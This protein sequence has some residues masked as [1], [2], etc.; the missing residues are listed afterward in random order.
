MSCC[1]NP[2]G[3]SDESASYDD[4]AQSLV[5]FALR[6]A[7]PGLIGTL[8]LAV[9]AI[10]VGWLPPPAPPLYRDSAI[11]FVALLRGDVGSWFARSLVIIGG[12]VLLQSWLVLGIDVMRGTVRDIRRLWAVLAA[13]CVPLL[14]V[15]PL[16]SR[17]VYSYFVQGKLSLTGADPYTTGVISIPGWFQDGVDP[18][19]AQ[20]P[21]P[22]GPLWLSLSR[23]VVA[24]VGPNVY[25][26]V[27][28]FRVLA[29]LGVVLM[30]YYVPRLAFL[31]GISAPKSL[32]LGV[33]NP[34]VLLLFVLSTHNDALMV[35][36]MV[37]GLVLVME[38]RPVTG[39]LLI[40]AAVAIKPIA[41]IALPFAGLLWAGASSSMGTRILRWCQTG[42]LSVAAF[43]GL[44][45][46][47]GTGFGWI[48]ALSTPGTVTTW[49][50]PPSA[51]GMI[52]G[53]LVEH[54]G[55][56]DHT[57]GLLAATRIIALVVAAVIIGWL[58]LK[59]EGRTPV[60]GLTLALLTIVLL[61]P[62]F[63][64]WYLLWILPL[65]AASGLSARALR[66]VLL[67]TAAGTL[68]SLWETSATADNHLDVNDGIAMLLTLA[69]VAIAVF[70]SRR[71]R[72]LVLGD[73]VSHGLLPEDRPAQ[74]RYDSLITRGPQPA[75]R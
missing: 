52:L 48:A 12:A 47:V 6:H 53:G 24:L 31:S 63:Q 54:I 64:S 68:Y 73:P 72:S 35:G 28:A 50:S 3:R 74:A 38:H 34:L 45:A 70:A 44:S 39:V 9:G 51:L 43:L 21:T 59:P 17:D 29:V 42:A 40:T 18:Q 27:L 30:A 36:L 19:W 10:G 41:V 2:A 46:V 5:G 65:A 15:P 57:A 66:A 69:V 61:G 32:W 20:T 16:F 62:T 75:G 55:L 23:G 58:C 13:W 14:L 4:Y 56:G 71:E 7:V 26:G 25:L 67:I 37:A 1:V 8:L 60:R 33:M 11:P 22:Y 49:L